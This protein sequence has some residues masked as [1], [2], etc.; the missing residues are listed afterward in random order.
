MFVD[1][2]INRFPFRIQTAGADNR[3]ALWPGVNTL[4]MAKE[5]TTISVAVYR[6]SNNWTH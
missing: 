1:H 3:H 5:T 2:V 6:F 4:R